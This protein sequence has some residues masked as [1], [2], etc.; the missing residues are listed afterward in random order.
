MSKY[1]FLYDQEVQVQVFEGSV[2]TADD[3]YSRLWKY[4]FKI[5]LVL[6]TVDQLLVVFHIR[7]NLLRNVVAVRS[8]FHHPDVVEQYDMWRSL[9]VKLR[10]LPSG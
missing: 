2:Y 3:I 9:Q 4:E 6:F 1:H 8:S 7:T 10:L 5:I